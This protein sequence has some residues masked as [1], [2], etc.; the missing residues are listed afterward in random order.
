M[1]RDP[2]SA[3]GT[4]YYPLV[5]KIHPF[6]SWRRC[7]KCGMDVRRE[8]VWKITISEQM[9]HSRIIYVCCEC[10]PVYSMAL[11]Y[12]KKEYNKYYPKQG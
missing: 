1:R 6:F 4:A 12:A 8:H 5:K 11:E 3:I 10:K 2:E 7:E 9:Y